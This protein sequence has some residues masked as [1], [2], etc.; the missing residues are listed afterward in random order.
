[1]RQLQ[2]TPCSSP[3]VAST[4]IVEGWMVSPR[5]SRRKSP[6]FSSTVTSDAGAGQ[7]MPQHHS[8]RP[9][10]DD[11]ACRFRSVPC[12]LPS[13]LAVCRRANT[14]ARSRRTRPVA[15]SRPPTNVSARPN[16][17]ASRPARS[18]ANARFRAARPRPRGC[19]NCRSRSGRRRRPPAPRSASRS[20]AP[21]SRSSI[22]IVCGFQISLVGLAFAQRRFQRGRD[23]VQVGVGAG[24]PVPALI[25]VAV[26][27]IA[28]DILGPGLDRRHHHR[29][30]VAGVE[31]DRRSRPCGRT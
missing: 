23:L 3:V 27:R 29:V 24:D 28:L 12:R 30:G 21:P 2:R 13:R 10:A 7:Q 14:P 5:K 16:A 15:A 31:R 1:M 18:R 4:S 26:A 6:C 19:R 9:A 8:R 25:L 20:S 11:A 17:I 22:V